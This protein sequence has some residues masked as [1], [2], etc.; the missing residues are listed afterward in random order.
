MTTEPASEERTGPATPAVGDRDPAGLVLLAA[1]LPFVGLVGGWSLAA[2]LQPADYDSVSESVSALAATSTPHRWVMTT[3]LLLAAVGWLGVA[4]LSRLPRPARALMAVGGLGTLAVVL[5]PMASRSESNA[6]HVVFAVLTFVVLSLWPAWSTPPPPGAPWPQRRRTALAATGVLVLLTVA[7]LLPAVTGSATFG[8]WERLLLAAQS[9]W[10]VVVAAAAWVAAGSPLGGPR[11]RRLLLFGPLVVAAAL[12]GTV[13]TIVIPTTVQTRH[14]RA[15]VSLSLDPRD[16]ARLTAPTVFGDVSV[17][18]GGI[19]PGLIVRPEVKD[20]ITDVLA[21]GTTDLSTLEPKTSEVDAV[22]AAAV[23]GT[24]LRFAAGSL[25]A[26]LLLAGLEAVLVPLW[27]RRDPMTIRLRRVLAPSLAAALTASAVTGIAARQTYD[28]SRTKGFGST[29]LI[30]YL[31]ENQNLLGEVESR[32]RQVSP[33][34]RNL[35]ALSSA[36]KNRYG[37]TAD[38]PVALRVLL[39]SDVHDANLY[40]MARTIV[41]EEGIDAVL[42]TGDIVDFGRVEEL[43][44]A[45][46]PEGI[47]SLGVPYLFTKGNHDA[48]SAGDQEILNR[49][50][51]VPNVVLLQPN[52]ETYQEADLGGLRIAGFNDPRWY[53]DSGVATGQAQQPTREAFVASFAGRAPLDIVASHHPAA[54]RGLAR[55]GLLVNGHMHTPAL[56]GNRIQVGTFSG[57]GPFSHYF[58]RAPGEELTGQPSAFDILDIGE[59]CRLVS[60]RRYTFRNVIEGRPVLDDVSLLNGSFIESDVFGDEQRRCVATTSVRTTAVARVLPAGQPTTPTTTGTGTSGKPTIARPSDDPSPW[61]SLTEPPVTTTT[62]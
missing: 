12:G 59:D 31:A 36:L 9:T 3:G 58:E 50:S 40:E 62:P 22:V 28:P 33:Y 57:G 53:G 15:E 60:L 25:A 35:L 55:A 26:A 30:G 47:A 46:I 38:K 32:A 13:A 51:R 37:P 49:L 44:A 43:D 23:R 61:T 52:A 4:A 1:L 10:L 6:V 2:A 11:G 27:R 20:N 45:G 5:A 24:A 54:V 18:F 7:L 8:L 16:S 34:I 17:T 41:R 14:Y 19:A 48:T 29:G 42:D 21:K 56:D 39:I